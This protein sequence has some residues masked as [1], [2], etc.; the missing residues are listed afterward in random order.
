M[1]TPRRYATAAQRQA[2]Y[3][4][5]RTQTPRPAETAPLLAAVPRLPTAPGWRRWAVLTRSA[6]ELLQA[7]QEEMQGYYDARTEAWQSS[8]RGE[9]FSA[10]LEE[11]TE[12][13]ELV[14]DLTT[15]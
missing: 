1:P 8:E 13:A 15:P 4:R 6:R 3:R 2:A 12:A 5:R 9:V 7:V 11:V 10:R 14:G